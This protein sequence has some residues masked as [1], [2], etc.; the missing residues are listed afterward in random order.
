V[1]L[2][3]AAM[4]NLSRRQRRGLPTRR[5]RTLNWWR[6]TTN[7]TSLQM[8]GGAS[9][10]VGPDGAT[11]DT[12]TRR[13]RAQSPKR[14][15]ADPTKRTALRTISGSCA[16]RGLTKG[17]ARLSVSGPVNGY[18]VTIRGAVEL[19]RQSRS[20]ADENHDGHDRQIGSA[21]IPRRPTAKG[22][23]V[24]HNAVTIHPP[25]RCAGFHCPWHNPSDHHMNTWTRTIRTDRHNLMERVCPHG[26]GHPDPDSLEWLGRI[27]VPDDGVHTCDGCCQR[28]PGNSGPI[29]T[30]TGSPP[31]SVT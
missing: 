27:G 12:R 31:G 8:T 13:A 1:L 20:S 16:I 30:E 3:I 2:P 21:R 10:K 28:S 9:D 15:W 4:S 14:R 7:S 23:D 11:A 19:L 5:L 25:S 22:F 18:P 6:R 26:I 17:T 29:G 24:S